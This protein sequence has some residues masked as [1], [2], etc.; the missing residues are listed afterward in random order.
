M[1]IV[2]PTVFGH[3]IIADLVFEAITGRKPPASATIEGQKGRARKENPSAPQT[4]PGVHSA[5]APK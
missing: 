1:D 4:L 5:L 2:H 3:A